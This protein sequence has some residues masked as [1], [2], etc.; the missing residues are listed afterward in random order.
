MVDVYG[1]KMTASN[2]VVCNFRYGDLAGVNPT[3]LAIVSKLL[4]TLL[5]ISRT[6]LLYSNTNATKLMWNFAI[7]VLQN[8]NSIYGTTSIVLDLLE[9]LKEM[10]FGMKAANKLED[11]LQQKYSKIFEI[12]LYISN[13][14]VFCKSCAYVSH[15]IVIEMLWIVTDYGKYDEVLSRILDNF[16]TL[17]ALA[18]FHAV[19]EVILAKF[20]IET[21][22]FELCTLWVMDDFTK[23]LKNSLIIEDRQI[24]G[25]LIRNTVTLIN[26]ADELIEQNPMYKSELLAFLRELLPLVDRLIILTSEPAARHL[27]AHVLISFIKQQFGIDDISIKVAVKDLPDNIKEWPRVTCETFFYL[28]HL[29]M[30]T[31]RML[32]STAEICDATSRLI[33]S[34]KYTNVLNVRVLKSLFYVYPFLLLDSEKIEK[35]R[36]LGDDLLYSVLPNIA[37]RIDQ[38]LSNCPLQLIWILF[39]ASREVKKNT[40]KFWLNQDNASNTITQLEDALLAAKSENLLVEIL[41]DDPNDPLATLVIKEIQNLQ[42]RTSF[43]EIPHLI[44]RVSGNIAIVSLLLKLGTLELHQNH[45]N[46]LE[47]FSSLYDIL[48]KRQL[49]EKTLT[50]LCK[51]AANLLSVL[52]KDRDFMH[53]MNTY[54]FWIRYLISCLVNAGDELTK[55]ILELLTKILKY[56]ERPVTPHNQVKIDLT[57]LLCRDIFIVKLTIEFLREVLGVSDL[58][59]L[60]E[61]SILTSFSKLCSLA[62]NPS[63]SSVVY[64]TLKVLLNQHPHDL[65]Y[66]P[67]LGMLIE[68]ICHYSNRKNH[69]LEGL[70][71]FRFWI[72]CIFKDY[73]HVCGYL[74]DKGF[75][76]MYLRRTKGLFKMNGYEEKIEMMFARVRN[77]EEGLLGR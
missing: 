36:L 23:I 4:P 61:S 65:V 1:G 68:D 55:A 24:L 22:T 17:G 76:K 50:N 49:D 43:Q 21:K 69:S 38:I 37:P 44:S 63:L 71:F 57:P 18:E 62:C 42:P 51:I 7:S 28:C 60:K 33:Y 8:F 70:K 72:K 48:R 52:K 67:A 64:D 12:L 20:P 73:F 45:S 46:A 10:W 66:T 9:L 25:T 53:R 19:A 31:K 54:E 74:P 56:Q 30:F 15:E 13:L 75:L 3:E 58:V 39:K 2:A 32:W 27:L 6:E 35:K 41:F 59:V 77:V 26:E 16:K 40:I 11:V 5:K 14:D 34:K 29:L 47:L